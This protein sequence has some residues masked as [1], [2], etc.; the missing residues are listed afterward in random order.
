MWRSGRR[1]VVFG[2]QTVQRHLARVLLLLK[3][4]RYSKDPFQ[5]ALDEG[6][7]GARG[8]IA[9]FG[10]CGKLSCCCRRH[11]RLPSGAQVC[12]TITAA[13]VVQLQ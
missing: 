7:D 9:G 13:A 11:T 4:T 10:A 1:S 6:Q 12:I 2:W 5:A 8:Q 3:C